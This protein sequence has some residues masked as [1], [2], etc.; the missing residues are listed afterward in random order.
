M[1]TS[2]WTYP[3]ARRVSSPGQLVAPGSVPVTGLG[4]LQGVQRAQ[5][6]ELVDAGPDPGGFA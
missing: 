6:L 5:R 1:S 2:A 4:L 3:P